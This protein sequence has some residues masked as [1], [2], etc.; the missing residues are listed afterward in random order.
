MKKLLYSVAIALTLC[1]VYACNDDNDNPGDFNLKAELSLGQLEAINGLGQVKSGVELPALEVETEM[2]STYRHFYD[3]KDAEGKV[4]TDA[5]GNPQKGY[6]DSKITGHIY[7]MKLCKIPAK[8]DTFRLTIKSNARWEAKQPEIGKLK[9]GRPGAQWFFNYNS[10]SAG[11]GDSKVEFRVIRNRSK[12]R[13]NIA[14]QYV[15]TSD[16]TVMY[17]IPFAQAGEKD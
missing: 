5:D 12:L 6:A 13:E 10:T 3:I 7:K 15:V 17:I 9:N 2:D 8:A 11:G 4:I 1:G 16:S 14:Y